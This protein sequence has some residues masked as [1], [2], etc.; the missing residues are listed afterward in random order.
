MTQRGTLLGGRYELD[1]IIGRGG[2]A[3]VWR[4]RDTRLERDVAVKRLRIDLASDPTFQARFRREAQSAAGLNHPNIV[5][6]Y[7]TGEELDP[8]SQV[9][10]PYIVMEL[11]EGVT[12]RDVLRDGRKILPER[13]LEFTAAVLDGLDYSHRAGIIHRD[14][15]PANVMLTPTGSVKVM[16]FGIA[17]AVADT[18]A[19]MTQTAAVIGTAQYLSPEQARGEKVDQRSDLY[20][21][22]CLLY[23]LLVSEPPFKGDSPVSV[24][25]QHVREAP[26]PPSQRDPEVTPGMDAVTLKALAKSADDRYQ[27]AREMRADVLR[28][29]NHEPVH[30]LMTAAGAEDATAV[31][32]ND[33]TATARRAAVPAAPVAVATS[34]SPVEVEEDEPEKK[35]RKG[36]IVLIVLAVLLLAGM[37]Y[38]VNTIMNPTPPAPVMV[39][40]PTVVGQDQISAQNTIKNGDLRSEVVEVMGT[41]ENKGKVVEQTP[42]GGQQ[43]VKDSVVTL[44]VSTGPDTKVIPADLVGMTEADARRALQ[45]AGFDNVSTTDADPAT[46]DPTAKQG[47]VV[48]SDPQPGAAVAPETVV[49]LTIA[50]GKS[51]VPQL[52]GFSEDE[53]ADLA[54]QSGFTKV[55]DVKEVETDEQPPGKV[56]DQFPRSGSALD[57]ADTIE[58]RI[59]VAPAVVT[60]P[61]P[62]ETTPEPTPTETTPEPTPTETTPEPTPAETPEPT[63]TPT[64]TADGGNG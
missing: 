12:L 54:K 32:A 35:S 41:E 64:A 42:E 44:K 23:E 13:A 19:T 1:Q 46:E 4:A 10:V 61:P 29:M 62:P 55:L 52:I 20:S 49:K 5:A 58:V 45:D 37:A 6:V 18:S 48:A 24:A 25:Y 7:D 2:M 39:Q 9:S 63:P 60:P 27:D 47:D 14:I 15:K 22:G 53:A 36:L 40:V 17:R 11:V 16:D 30:A 8:S 34:P 31:M 3:E 21:V 28:A 59:A 33:P 43:A 56:F 57:R 26:V 51:I 50:T 38:A